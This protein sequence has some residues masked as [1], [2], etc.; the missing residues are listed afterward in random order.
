MKIK[1]IS[2]F[3]YMNFKSYLNQPMQKIERRLNMN[4]AK[5]PQLINSINRGSDHHFIRKYIDVPFNDQ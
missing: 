3:N 4:I 1:T 5:N 2:N